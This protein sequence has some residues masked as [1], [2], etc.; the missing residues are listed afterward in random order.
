[1]DLMEELDQ[2][3]KGMSWFRK[4][5]LHVHSPLS[6]DWPKDSK[7]DRDRKGVLLKEPSPY[8][9]C[10]DSRYELVAI[11]DHMRASFACGHC[12]KAK[13]CV[14]LPGMELNVRFTKP[15]HSPVVHFLAIFPEGTST[16][17]MRPI[18]PAHQKLP[19]DKDRDG[20]EVLEVDSLQELVA[21]VRDVGGILIAAHVDNGHRSA[22]RDQGSGALELV[23]EDGE[24]L[25]EKACKF[26]DQYKELLVQAGVHAVE[27]RRPEDARHY[28]FFMGESQREVATVLAN[29]AHN[30]IQLETGTC[31][32]AKMADVSLEGLRFALMFPDTRIRHAQPV[33]PRPFLEGV[34][35]AGS[36]GYFA[37]TTVAFSPNLTCVIGARG[38]GK[39]ALVDAIRFAFGYNRKMGKNITDDLAGKVKD[40]QKETL[41]GGT[42]EVVYSSVSEQKSKLLSNYSHTNKDE[43]DTTV[44]DE[45]GNDRKI[46]NVQTHPDFPCRLFG[47]SEIEKL[48]SDPAKQRVVLD[49]ILNTH[50]LLEERNALRIELAADRKRIEGLA[51]ELDA[52]HRGA[53]ELESLLELRAEHKFLRSPEVD[54]LFKKEEAEA[55]NKGLAER[56]VSSFR[57]WSSQLSE[58]LE[59]VP[60]PELKG[61][62]DLAWKSASGPKALEDVREATQS[63]MSAARLLWQKSTALREEF[64]SRHKAAVTELQTK[65]KGSSVSVAELA[66]KRARLSHRL[67]T[68]EE[69]SLQY[70]EKLKG[71][72]AAIRGRREKVQALRGILSTISVERA[73]GANRITEQ[74]S[75]VDR[76]KIAVNLTPQSDTTAH[77]L[78]LDDALQSAGVRMAKTRARMADALYATLEPEDLV[79]VV[80]SNKTEERGLPTEVQDALNGA[81]FPFSKDED[82]G[83]Q[84]VSREVLSRLLE[85]DENCVDDAVGITLDGRPITKLSPGTVCSALLPVILTGSTDP[86]ILDQPEDNLDNKLVTDLVIRMLRE[87]KLRRQII[88]VTHNPNIVVNG[89]AE[90]VVVM[91][92]D[93][94]RCICRHQAA[95]DDRVVMENIMA[96]M[97]GGREALLSRYKC[98]EEHIPDFLKT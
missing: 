27:I 43:Y 14:I 87:L 36:A 31:T 21:S 76:P 51:E 46:G 68:A 56:W 59:H 88:I 75:H 83:M 30:L 73:S 86:L 60:T 11:T 58:V 54:E 91:D 22:F 53:R 3:R 41:E 72:M 5:A 10:L 79:Q 74:L 28:Q 37:D 70:G 19:D 50:K 12:D 18:F 94:G 93:E 89:D 33:E 82:S 62:V 39:S 92:S 9:E 47:W 78:W 16:E 15:F 65:A 95:L 77:K 20:R 35:I 44:F 23:R 13:Q 98:Y 40:R 97:E 63:L 1:M 61:D 25:S 49:H 81:L 69:E 55:H 64:E 6:Y 26:G 84:R 24:E 71:L 2:L 7:E 17:R 80:L 34:R 32:Y 29:D 90:Q 52:F 85:S 66:A 4:V 8:F 45:H 48:G 42:I 67:R 57:D 38:T 96:L